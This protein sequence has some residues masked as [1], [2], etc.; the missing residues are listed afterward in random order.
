MA[1]DATRF[2][3]ILRHYLHKRLATENICIIECPSDDGARPIQGSAWYAAHA[4]F[5]RERQT[6]GGSLHREM[7]FGVAVG[8]YCLIKGN[9]LPWHVRRCLTSPTSASVV[10]NMAS[11]ACQAPQGDV[12]LHIHK[13]KLASRHIDNIISQMLDAQLAAEHSIALSPAGLQTCRWA[14]LYL[15]AQYHPANAKQHKPII[16]R[17]LSNISGDA[18]R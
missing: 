15:S 2:H 12:C 11:D 4:L 16:T 17:S 7:I 18:R 1:A 6:V 13:F 9:R 8:G 14:R 10:E 5:S 3:A